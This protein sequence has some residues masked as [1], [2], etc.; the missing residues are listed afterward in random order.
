MK[1]GACT[2]RKGAKL[3]QKMFSHIAK[4]KFSLRIKSVNITNFAGNLVI[5]TEKILNGKIQFLCSVNNGNECFRGV[6]LNI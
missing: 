6:I 5:F 1:V 4:K 2:H 3:R